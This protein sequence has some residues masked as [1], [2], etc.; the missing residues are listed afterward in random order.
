VNGGPQTDGGERARPADKVVRLP[1]DWLGPREDLVPF[2]PRAGGAEP[3]PSLPAPEAP[4]SAADFW[5][6]RSAAIHDAV[7]APAEEPIP[8]APAIPTGVEAHDCQRVVAPRGHRR[9]L[10]ATALTIAAIAGT[11][12]MLGILGQS[13]SASNDAGSARLNV[14]TIL[15][16]GVSRTLQRGIASLDASTRPRQATATARSHRLAAPRTAPAGLAFRPTHEPGHS[17][18][19]A[20]VTFTA[21]PS[22]DVAHSTPHAAV[23]T[24]E[25]AVV[26]TRVETRRPPARSRT[27][28]SS[29]AS[30]NPTGE[31]GALG[32][33]QSPNG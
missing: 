26:P 6:E 23:H 30:V 33:V 13:G 18:P 8:V 28:G 11:S 3:E 31:A 24:Y 1:R 29:T 12:Q 25:P 7:Q 21:A 20:P 14:A 9:V 15:D 32:P 16:D 2:G 17:Q 19:A 22:V 27:S 5:G 4:P 10:A